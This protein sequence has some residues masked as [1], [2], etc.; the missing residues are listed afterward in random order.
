MNDTKAPRERPA[1]EESGS[2]ELDLDDEA[3]DL[4]SVFDE[5]VR[6]VER[7]RDDPEAEDAAAD[8]DDAAP[9][10]DAAPQR[11]EAEEMRDRLARTLADFDNFRKRVEREKETARR[12]AHSD[13]LRDV[14][15]V[16]DNLER[17]VTATGEL[18]DLRLGVEMTLKQV[19]DVLRRYGVERVVAEGQPFDPNL[20][21]A[22]SRQE[23]AEVAAPTVSQELQRG[24]RYHDR[25][26]RPAMVNVVV[27]VAGE[28]DGDRD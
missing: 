15:A 27:P 5:A 6:A 22:V 21:E 8:G 14:L 16:V 9:P 11:S 24:Y 25:L 2:Y 20:H 4:D 28:G 18:E 3:G 19:H 26:L 13:L 17:A 10:A 12:Y 1:D 7:H 23:S